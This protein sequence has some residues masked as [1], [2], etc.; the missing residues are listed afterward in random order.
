MKIHLPFSL[1]FL[2]HRLESDL[3]EELR[4]H[5]AN[6]ADDLGRGGLRTSIL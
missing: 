2:F 3:E 6:R 4:S 5:I 1:A